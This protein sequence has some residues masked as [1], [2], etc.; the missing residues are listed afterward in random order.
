M[1]DLARHTMS[2]RF[3]RMEIGAGPESTTTYERAGS[4]RTR[5]SVPLRKA[6]QGAQ[7]CELDALV[8]NLGF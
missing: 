8:Y 2:T 6:M 4:G 5:Q 7:R 3:V 1:N